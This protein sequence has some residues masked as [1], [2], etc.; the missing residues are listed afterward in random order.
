MTTRWRQKASSALA[1]VG[2]V[3]LL[4][5]LICLWTAVRNGAFSETRPRES[6]TNAAAGAEGANAM[7]YNRFAT[8]GSSRVAAGSLGVSDLP[9][10]DTAAAT[11]PRHDDGRRECEKLIPVI[12][13]QNTEH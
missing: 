8:N 3:V 10:N 4:L 2:V 6:S 9:P 12:Y 11:A 5:L 7:L 1:V 13:L